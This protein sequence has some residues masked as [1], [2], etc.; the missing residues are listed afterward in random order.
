MKYVFFQQYEDDPAVG[1]PYNIID[2][3]N[4]EHPGFPKKGEYYNEFAQMGITY[5]L[6][7]NET[8]IIIN[9][10]TILELD[11]KIK[12][13]SNKPV[14]HIKYKEGPMSID[15]DIYKIEGSKDIYTVNIIEAY[16]YCKIKN[17][18]IQR[19][20][21]N[22]TIF[23]EYPIPVEAIIWYEPTPEDSGNG[24]KRIIRKLPLRLDVKNKIIKYVFGEEKQGELK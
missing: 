20:N 14:G 1:I 15:T 17:N 7:D 19:L 2:S 21:I 23:D 10:G 16:I 12:N 13:T 11:V 22:D 6:N 9:T 5:Y 8:R 24:L 18:I 3:H 4:T